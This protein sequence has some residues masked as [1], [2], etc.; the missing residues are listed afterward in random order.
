[1]VYL[2][3]FETDAERSGYT[4]DERLMS[5]TDDI[6]TVHL[7]KKQSTEHLTFRAVSDGTFAFSG[8]ISGNVT[9]TISYSLD[10]GETWSEYANRVELNVH[11]G[12]I[13]K[14]KGL[15][16]AFQEYA[17][18][19]PTNHAGIGTFSGSTALFNLEGNAMS[20]L[21]E[22]E[23]EGET[24]LRYSCTFNLLFYKS[25]VSNANA[26]VLPAET[27]VKCCYA[28]MFNKCENLTTAPLLPATN[29]ASFCYFQMF[30]H[31][32]RLISSPALPATDLAE[33][34]YHRMFGDC[35]SIVVAPVLRGEIMKK[36]CYESM[37]AYCSS[38]LIAPELSSTTLYDNCYDH[39]FASCTS[40]KIAPNLPA[41]QVP[42]SGYSYMFADCT[43]LTTPPVIEATSFGGGDTSQQYYAH[44]PMEYMFSGCTSLE[45][46]PVLKT[47]VLTNECYRY[48]F[49]GCSKLKSITMLATDISASN[50]LQ[51][52]V[53]GVAASGTFTK[54]SSTSIPTGINGIPSGWN[55]VQ[56]S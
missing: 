43:S 2:K 25:K 4:S 20:L 16:Q 5:Y 37:F 42:L 14:W 48:M 6:D 3:N 19:V 52:W 33:S 50:C 9:N 34:C 44:K 36:S 46:S 47:K 53:S 39:M 18:G 28:N 30:Q 55:V 22:D 40:L 1:M 31:C 32:A 17:Y 7:F 21:Y 27:L 15:M 13:V 56:A 38:L 51:S 54:N 10:D 11:S 45:E 26:L 24:D 8:T 29:L 12:D 49:Y 23:F 41:T 35:A